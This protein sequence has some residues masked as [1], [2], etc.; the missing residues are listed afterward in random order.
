MCYLNKG[1][2]TLPT[3]LPHVL[4]P[5]QFKYSNSS[6]I[7]EI[8]W[9]CI[10]YGFQFIQNIYEYAAAGKY[11]SPMDIQN[12][13]TDWFFK[14][15]DLYKNL[16]STNCLQL[17]TAWMID[18]LLF[19]VPLENF[20]SINHV[21]MKGCKKVY[22][23]WTQV[24]SSEEQNLNHATAAVYNTEPRF[25]TSTQVLLCGDAEDHAG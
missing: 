11:V 17:C 23:L 18:S 2:D 12:L 8:Q 24:K 14:D 1:T 6:L 25:Q 7:L 10:S 20:H 22:M 9:L 4:N 3:P 15:D 5:L 16:W 19:T 13:N 21:P